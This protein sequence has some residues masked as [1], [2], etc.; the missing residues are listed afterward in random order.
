M[1]LPSNTLKHILV[2]YIYNFNY[3]VLLFIQKYI[4]LFA[5]HVENRRILN[6]VVRKLSKK[7]PTQATYTNLTPG[8]TTNIA[9]G[10]NFFSHQSYRV[11]N[12]IFDD[13][14]TT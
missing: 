8:R 6:S 5:G 1:K 12:T 2:Q 9:L 14:D 10:T 4:A 7:Q 3:Y 13:A 11:C